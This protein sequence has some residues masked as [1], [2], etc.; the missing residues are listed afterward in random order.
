MTYGRESI[1]FNANHNVG[2]G[3][4]VLV[5]TFSRVEEPVNKEP[6]TSDIVEAYSSSY[7]ETLLL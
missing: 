5:V 3:V 1:S 2:E 4:L 7:V 6:L